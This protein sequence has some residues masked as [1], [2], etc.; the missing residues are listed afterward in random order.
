M[1]IERNVGQHT[2]I[3][4]QHTRGMRSK[5]K[6][7]LLKLC[8]SRP[9]TSTSSRLH[10][11]IVQQATVYLHCVCEYIISMGRRS[12]GGLPSNVCRLYLEDPELSCKLG[13]ISSVMSNSI[14]LCLMTF[15][16]FHD[17]FDPPS[18]KP[19]PAPLWVS[20]HPL[21]AP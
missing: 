15:H 7:N 14:T 11:D 21:H 20:S 17:M 6:S 4:S 19:N 16:G 5:V 13:P 9:L 2:R 3:I 12:L 8:L 18:P 10:F 1:K